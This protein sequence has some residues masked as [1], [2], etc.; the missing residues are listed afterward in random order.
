[1]GCPDRNVKPWFDVW[2]AHTDVHK[3]RSCYIFTTI[4]MPIWNKGATII[5]VALKNQK[6]KV[7]L[8]A[9][10]ILEINKNEKI[11]V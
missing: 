4:L 11:L 2:E 3:A 10:E 7:T 5:C 9:M 1:M 8:L 6:A